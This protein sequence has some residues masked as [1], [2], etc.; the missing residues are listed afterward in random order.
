MKIK[1]YMF[2]II[3][4]LVILVISVWTIWEFTFQLQDDLVKETYRTL[5][6][7]SMDYNKVFLDRIS[8]NVKTMN[9]L[10]NNLKEMQN[11]TK[12]DIMEILQNAVDG[13]GFS[14]M[15]VC[16]SSGISYSSDGISRDVSGRD[17]FQK[18][19]RGETDAGKPMLTELNGEKSLIIAVPIKKSETIIGVLFGVYPSQTAG[20]H[21]LDFNYYSKG[22]G[23]IID[24]GGNIILSSEHAD[25]L[26]DEDNL[27]LFFE[28]T[29]LYDIS[30]AEIKTA[31]E[32]GES[33]CFEFSY[34]GAR[35]FVSFAP[36]TVNDWYT[37]SIASDEL[38]LEQEKT[39][40]KIVLKLI[41]GLVLAGSLLF[42][43]YIN[44][45]KNHNRRIVSANQKYQSLLDNI[46]GGM[47]VVTYAKTAE[48]SL[49]TY[50]STG[51][52]KMTGYTLDDINK[53]HGG[54]Y[55]DLLLEEDRQDA[56]ESHQKQISVGKTYRIPY[57]I[58]KKDGPILWIM[59]NGY[60]VD[61]MDGLQNNSILTDITLVKQQEQELRMSEKRFSVAI[62]ASSGTLFEVDLKKQM[63]THFENA[64]RIFGVSSQK[65]MA[66]TRVFSSLPFAEFV[67]AV[68]EYFFYPDDRI[69]AKTKMEK[70]MKDK[71]ASYE[72]RLRRG[73]DTYIWARIDLSI[74][75]DESGAPARL[76]G[77]M[78]D[79]D[80]IKKQ[81]ELL[82]NRV[83]TDSMTGLYNKV[84]MTTL[85]QKVL[86]DYPNGLHALLVL[87]I[88]NFKG[89]N[90]TLGHAF[91]DLVLIEACAKL[92][93]A[94]RNNDIVGRMGGDEF[95]VLMKNVP[96]T[97][98]VLKK[99]TEISGAFRQTYEGEKEKY[100]ISC[101]IGIIMIEENRESFETLYRKADA[102][103]YQAKQGGKDQVVLYR[104]EEEESYPIDIA[105]T[106]DEELQNLKVSQNIEAQIF[107]LLYTS[108]DFNISIGMALA[109]IGKRY[110]VSRVA[111]FENDESEHTTSNVYE[112]CNEGIP[113]K[114][115][116][117]QNLKLTEN[118]DSIMDCFDKD[119]M[120]Y[121][122]DVGELPPYL[123]HILEAR[124]VLSTLKVTILND[125]MTCGYIG[126]DECKDH[127]VWT[128]EEIEKLSY[129]SKVLSVFLFKK[130]AEDRVLENLHTRLQI[131]DVLPDYV[132]VVNPNTHSLEYSN[133]RMQ[134]LFPQVKP[135]ALCFTTLRGGQSGPCETCLIERIKRGDTDNLEIISTDTRKRL[136][137]DALAIKWSNDKEM[138]LLYG[139][140]KTCE[141]M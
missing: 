64:E 88:D 123:R 112:W 40:N 21:L 79:I 49:A 114:M 62:N 6:E 45:V 82:K 73:D 110:H 92:K 78:S 126:F 132:C 8:F 29:E 121:C 26:S 57:R 102:A 18:T 116:E 134:E 19:M 65:L 71:K 90:D 16:N 100:Q 53:L 27:F 94:F 31:I 76:V 47:V 17:Y 69:L 59:D 14:K 51:F 68:T 67:D 115:S 50:V 48:E 70:L 124:G 1:N 129:L 30:M 63:Y 75:L 38:M 93:A 119:G 95:A 97:S 107:E 41:M 109:A 74:S 10:A 11:L 39:T 28:K 12:Q 140:K 37:F 120:L 87:D 108:K 52:T 33:K 5:S 22:Y 101:S 7:V 61:G 133:K 111:I 98:S 136:R 96:D 72:A 104:A 24:P 128:S 66:D 25:K 2:K 118:S 113:A 77:F 85:S 80:D 137:V 135:G 106:N 44:G 127:R 81:S 122:N 138:V 103:L 84:A 139:T 131:L 4:I 20:V 141:S 13:V 60:L 55:I 117:L 54:R 32:K 89:V 36:S 3:C 15:V 46:N 105:R 83:Q 43:Y 42:I 99:A 35:R 9:I 58:R 125:E 86:N 23:F 91:G 34:G 56:F 130:K